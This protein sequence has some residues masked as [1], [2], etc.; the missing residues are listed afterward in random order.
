MMRPSEPNHYNTFGPIEVPD[1]Y[2]LLLGATRD[3]SADFRSIGVVSRERIMG[4]AHTVAFSVDY[5]AYYLP[6]MDRFIYSLA[7][8]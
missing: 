6:R 3:N 8:D 2:Y 5:N 1:G 7:V 4:R